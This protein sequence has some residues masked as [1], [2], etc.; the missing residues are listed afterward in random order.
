MEQFFLVHVY[1]YNKNKGWNVQAVTTQELSNCQV[2]ENPTG[3]IGSLKMKINKK[4]FA[5]SNSPADKI[6][7]FPR[8]SFTILHI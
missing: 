8:I 7:S 4:L 2:E 6:L 3:Q 1:L 5:K